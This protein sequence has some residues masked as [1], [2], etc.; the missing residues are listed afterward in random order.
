M[1][2]LGYRWGVDC[3]GLMALTVAG[4]KSSRDATRGLLQ[5]VLNCYGACG[6]ILTDRGPKFKG[7]FL[8]LLS[9]HELTNRLASREHPQSDGL[10]Y[11]LSGDAGGSMR[12]G[13]AGFLKGEGTNF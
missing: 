5:G 11:T 10:A 2:G 9:K 12:G 8:M 4:N 7:E 1:Q 13:D 6:E 3:T